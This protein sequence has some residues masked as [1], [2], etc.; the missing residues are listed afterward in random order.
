MSPEEFQ[1]AFT[2]A[3]GWGTYRQVVQNSTMLAELL[4]RWGRL[5]MKAMALAV[6]QLPRSVQL[7]VDGQ[8]IGI[9]HQW[10]AS[11]L[12]IHLDEEA[13]LSAGQKVAVKV[14]W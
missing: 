12:T 14:G 10:D 5:R 9:T 7:L 4:L 1:A 2:S 8:Q 11:R 13:F 3:E 6:A